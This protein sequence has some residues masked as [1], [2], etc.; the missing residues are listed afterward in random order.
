MKEFR[1]GK[2][3]LALRPAL[4]C[5]ALAGVVATILL[6]NWQTRRAEEKLA[7]QGRL[8]AL[9]QG[10][11]LT[12]PASPVTAVDFAQSRVSVRGEFVPQDTVFVDNRVLK[13]LPGYHV[14]T[15]L[16]ING[17]DTC[18]LVNRGWVAVGPTRSR[19][20]QVP[21]P[22]G[23][24]LLEGVAV[25]PPERVYELAADTGTGPVVQHLYPAQIAERSG[26]R[27]Q[28][29]VLQQT[30]DTPDGLVRVWEP[31]DSGANT[32]RAYALQWYALAVLIA[33]LYITLNLRRMH[34]PDVSD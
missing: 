19:L 25:V 15:P 32:N 26:L 14:V 24:L 33:V 18:V 1:C 28:P 6:G 20:P 29:V 34:G 27:L 10:P 23:E 17:G 5:V 11:I 8:D 7:V 3:R 13:G 9:A 16:R 4:A 21:A 22:T 30:S 31:P 2:W 12:L